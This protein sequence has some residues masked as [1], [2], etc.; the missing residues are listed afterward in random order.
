[1][2]KQRAPEALTRRIRLRWDHEDL[3]D[4]HLVAIAQERYLATLSDADR[5]WSLDSLF[6]GRRIDFSGVNQARL[7]SWIDLCVKQHP[8]PCNSLG[9]ESPSRFKEMLKHSYFGVI[10]VV[11]MQ[12]VRLPNDPSR[13]DAQPAPYAALS[14]VW[15]KDS[16]IKRT[17]RTLENNINILRM[18]GGLER[19]MPEL[20]PVIRDTIDLVRRLDMQFVW[21][22]A[23]CIVQD[24]AKSWRL[25]AYNM[26]IIYG[27]AKLT[28]CAADGAES[29]LE[30]AKPS[31]NPSTQ[32]TAECV[33]DLHL[34]LVRTPDSYIKASTWNTRAWTFQ[35]RLVSR[36]CLVFVD[37]RVFFQCPSTGMSE[38][39]YAD[40]DG[41]GWSLDLVDAPMRMFKQISERSFWVYMNIA[42]LYSSRKLSKGKDIHAAFYGITIRM[43]K[44]M[45]A[46]FIFGLPSSHLDLA[47]LWQHTGPAVRRKPKDQEELIDY[48]ELRYPSWSW[49]G[50]SG[51][52]I[53][54]SHDMISGCI[55][56]TSEWLRNHTW[57]RWY[58]RDGTGDLRPLWDD[59]RWR[60]DRSDD[61]TWRGYGFE[62]AGGADLSVDYTE[63]R[64]GWYATFEK[65]P[66]APAE[67]A[68]VRD[69]S[70]SRY[71]ARR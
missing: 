25:N 58:V 56:N 17:F 10:D 5:A 2:M 28:I 70:P 33:E 47:L 57:I 13:Q 46:P 16:E 68:V 71:M 7:N 3:E 65:R 50:W 34:M 37:G 51:P 18:H 23:L 35:E 42:E 32:M 4:A 61:A 49:M 45:K 31:T 15:G 6:L 41:T 21:I 27:N 39:V 38:D 12:L 54:Y 9:M 52:P 60:I 1:M 14:Y 48:G 66:G 36:R 69:R 40:R 8:H 11:N 26:D 30:A 29:G 20:P 62:R 59:Q 53:S 19:F 43:K 64:N 22:D 67:L 63:R 44:V 55:D 24:S